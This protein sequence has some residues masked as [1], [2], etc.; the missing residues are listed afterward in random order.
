MHG[1]NVIIHFNIILLS[2]PSST[3]IFISITS[4]EILY[5]SRLFRVEFSPHLMILNLIIL[6]I[7]GTAQKM[8][9]T[10]INN[11]T[12]Y[13]AVLNTS[14]FVSILQ[15]TQDEVQWNYGTSPQS[16]LVQALGRKKR[17]KFRGITDRSTSCLHGFRIR[18][19]NFSVCSGYGTLHL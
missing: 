8:T 3:K 14:L 5:A 2:T 15:H 11:A 16:L 4:N 10:M 12:T 6:L 18:G 7:L 9:V 19:R 1:K 17:T 13:W